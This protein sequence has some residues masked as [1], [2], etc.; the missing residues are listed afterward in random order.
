MHRWLWVREE[1]KRRSLELLARFGAKGRLLCVGCGDGVEIGIA[2]QLGW[3]PDGYDVDPDVTAEVARK[4][5]V[6]MHSGDFFSIAAADGS[7]DAVFMDQVL[8]HLKNPGDYLR[9]VNALLRPGGVLVL[10]LPNIGS[11]SNRLKTLAGKLGLQRRRRGNHYATKHHLFY[12][13][14]RPT[15]ALLERRFG[16]EVLRLSGSLKP[17]KKKLTP[18][19]SRW[20]PSVDSGFF[21]VARKVERCAV[22]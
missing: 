20:F 17:Q 11:F 12:F 7:Y 16:F 3:D 21:A 18:M 8:E 4:Y 6:V 2:R 15:R 19:L 9:K 22:G 1:A 5:G 13:A 10:G 14:P